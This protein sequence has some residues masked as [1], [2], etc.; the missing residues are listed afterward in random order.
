MSS[1]KQIGNTLTITT[2]DDPVSIQAQYSPDKVT[3]HTTW[4]NGLGQVGIR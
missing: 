4:Q 3:V 2:M 1:R